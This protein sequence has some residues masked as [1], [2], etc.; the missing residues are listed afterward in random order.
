M[1]N[2]RTTARFCAKAYLSRPSNRTR[3]VHVDNVIEHLDSLNALRHLAFSTLE[4]A[5]NA[6]ARELGRKVEDDYVLAEVA[7]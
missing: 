4:G 5:V 1:T 6:A 2:A 7:A 3:A